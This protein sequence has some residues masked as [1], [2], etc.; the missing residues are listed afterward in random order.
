[1]VQTV[2]ATVWV[3]WVSEFYYTCELSPP[4]NPIGGFYKQEC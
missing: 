1:M 3:V 2:H 4:V